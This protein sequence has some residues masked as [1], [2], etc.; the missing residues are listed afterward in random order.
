MA[1]DG[2]CGC[3]TPV[4]GKSGRCPDCG[5]FIS[6]KETDN[7]RARRLADF[8]YG[9]EREHSKACK[10]YRHKFLGPLRFKK[11][12]SEHVRKADQ[13]NKYRHRYTRF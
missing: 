12:I 10:L 5:T 7:S 11:K 13:A 3:R 2:G 6:V 4:S 8:W 1:F 9:L